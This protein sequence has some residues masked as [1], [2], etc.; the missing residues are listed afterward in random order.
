MK[1]GTPSPFKPQA[2]T[3][4]KVAEMPDFEAVAHKVMEAHAETFRKLAQSE[5]AQPLATM[6]PS[7]AEK[8]VIVKDKLARRH[9]KL[10][11]LSITKELSEIAESM[12]AQDELFHILKRGIHNLVEKNDALTARIQILESNK[13]QEKHIVTET[14]IETVV[15]TNAPKLMMAGIVLSIALSIFAILTH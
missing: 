14:K 5:K 10:M 8:I 7:Q 12:S 1:F 3:V 4:Q 13:V 6:L 9:G 15:K 2:K 11:R